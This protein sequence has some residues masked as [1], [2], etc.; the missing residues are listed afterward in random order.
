MMAELCFPSSVSLVDEHL[1]FFAPERAKRLRQTP[2]PC[3]L[4][5]LDLGAYILFTRYQ[6]EKFTVFLRL[7]AHAGSFTHSISKRV[8][9]ISSKHSPGGGW[10]VLRALNVVEPEQQQEMPDNSRLVVIL[11]R[12][13]LGARTGVGRWPRLRGAFHQR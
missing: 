2:H 13:R 6:H 10:F 8:A 5:R 11:H 9:P 12:K 7:D 1:G 4:Y 3:P